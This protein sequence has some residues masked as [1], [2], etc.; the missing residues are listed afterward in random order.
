MI[1]FTTLSQKPMFSVKD[2]QNPCR[3]HLLMYSSKSS[4]FISSFFPTLNEKSVFPVAISSFME[5][6]PMLEYAAASFI[7][8]Q[9][10][11]QIGT[12]RLFF[13]CS[14]VLSS[15]VILCWPENAY[16]TTSICSQPPVPSW[17]DPFHNS[18]RTLLLDPYSRRARICC[19]IPLDTFLLRF[20]TEDSLAG[21][22]RFW[23]LDRNTF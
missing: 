10:L 14:I 15:F 16:N 1:F 3:Q 2:R 11:C 21:C 20:R 9:D 8:R 22:N 17:K 7:V 4:R 19:G 6:S 13:S 12:Y 5:C 18:S 23:D